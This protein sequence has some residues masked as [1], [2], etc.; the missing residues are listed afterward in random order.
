MWRIAIQLRAGDGIDGTPRYFP[1]SFRNWSARKTSFPQAVAEL[2]LA[3]VNDNE[4]EAAY[5]RND[6]M[7]QR[8]ALL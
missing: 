1:S 2:C 8:A 5:L 3:H 6:M 7:H 4:T